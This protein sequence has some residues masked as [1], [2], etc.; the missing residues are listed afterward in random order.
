MGSGRQ[1]TSMGAGLPQEG[2]RHTCTAFP[3]KDG[4][5]W[6]SINDGFLACSKR[7]E[8]ADVRKV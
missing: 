8:G 5:Q 2:M 4:A 3:A 6:P 7:K 1:T